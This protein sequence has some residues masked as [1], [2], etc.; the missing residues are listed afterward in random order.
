MGETWRYRA[1]RPWQRI[2][3]LWSKW[4]PTPPGAFRILTLHHIPPAQLQGL[5]RLLNYLL[6]ENGLLTPAEAESRLEGRVQGSEG[7]RVPYLLTFDDGFS[8][9]RRAA[10]EV[11]DPLGVKAVFFLCPGLMDFPPARQPEAIAHHICEGVVAAG[12][13]PRD[14]AIMSWDEAASLA[15]AGHTIGSHSLSHRRLAGLEPGD[16]AQEVVTAARLLKQRLGIQVT[17]F[18]YPFGDVDSIDGPS[19]GVVAR[20]H[21]FCA[22]GLRGLNS[23]RTNSLGLFREEISL[24]APFDYQRLVLAGGLDV[25]Y[26]GRRRRLERMLRGTGSGAGEGRETCAAS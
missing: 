24:D 19:L 10:A 11:L 4:A 12:E 13:L 25:F 3:R 1:A 22:S 15:A 20:E 17:W 14:M 18:A 5:R 8:S 9:N 7:G 23:A 6:E 21:R 2:H 26:R 16:Q